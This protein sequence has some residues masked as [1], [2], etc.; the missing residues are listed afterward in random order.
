MTDDAS[1]AKQVRGLNSDGWAKLPNDLLLH[2]RFR[3][4][5]C[6][7]HTVLWII[8]AH[9]NM[10]SGLAYPSRQTIAD[11]GGV[12]LGTVDRC[13]AELRELGV[14]TWKS[15]KGGGC[16]R[17]NLYQ[18]PLMD[19]SNSRANEAIQD[20]IGAPALG[21]SRASANRIGAPARQEHPKEQTK[22]HAADA[23]RR[24]E[25]RR[26][27]RLDRYN[28]LI[29][30]WATPEE[31]DAIRP[32]FASAEQLCDA[33]LVSEKEL[34]GAPGEA[35]Y[36]IVARLKPPETSDTAGHPSAPESAQPQVSER[37]PA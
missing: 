36:A 31:L 14:L 3:E 13:L 4:L 21:N 2:P 5:K 18:I 7:S 8:A 37:V 34:F 33:N 1:L 29:K 35:L 24:L 9:R 17:H 26:R 6:S 16:K 27:R 25:G 30:Q 23:A 22:E 20:G 15:A 12:S 19:A 10:A 11:I 28:L 32:H